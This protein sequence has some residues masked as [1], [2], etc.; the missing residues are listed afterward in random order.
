MKSISIP[1]KQLQYDRK[2]IRGR[3]AIKKDEK[4][5]KHR[6]WSI[7][8]FY[9]YDFKEEGY[10]SKK[11]IKKLQEIGEE[12][13]DR[14]LL[15]FIKQLEQTRGLLL[16]CTRELRLLSRTPRYKEQMELIR[17]VPGVFLE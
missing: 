2:M 1:S 6:I 17:S 8:F 10:W 11:V 15:L 13:G 4:R 7:I 16:E 9:G 5:I 12:K 3:Y 14:T